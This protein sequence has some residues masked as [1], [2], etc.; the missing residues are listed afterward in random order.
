MK[1]TPEGSAKMELSRNKR[2]IEMR[3]QEVVEAIFKVTKSDYVPAGVR[4]RSRINATMFTGELRDA[5]L[6]SIKHDVNVV[7]V[8][9][10][11][12]LDLIE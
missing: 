11:K 7:S 8:A 10:S 12:R 2:G 5:S 4:V 3:R 6:E 9:V 1:I